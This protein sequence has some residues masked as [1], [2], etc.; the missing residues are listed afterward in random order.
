MTRRRMRWRLSGAASP[1][2]QAY[3]KAVAAR[4]APVPPAQR[5]ALDSAYAYGDGATSPASIPEIST[6]PRCTPSR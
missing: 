5:A 2:E 1:W 3:I 4:Y 6:R